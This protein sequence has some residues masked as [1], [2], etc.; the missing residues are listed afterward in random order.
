M[1]ST[2]F[3]PGGWQLQD[4]RGRSDL[5]V[6][7]AI[8]AHAHEQGFPAPSTELIQDWVNHKLAHKDDDEA[9]SERARFHEILGKWTLPAKATGPRA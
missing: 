3:L 6:L 4:V 5:D 1:L 7:G 8:L 9:E 2:E